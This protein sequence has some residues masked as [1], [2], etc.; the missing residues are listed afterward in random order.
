M[1]LFR[2]NATYIYVRGG[3]G[4]ADTTI[5]RSRSLR[6][7]SRSHLFKLK[8]INKLSISL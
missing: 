7:N 8:A 6:L 2:P 1:G 5:V 3:V 4:V